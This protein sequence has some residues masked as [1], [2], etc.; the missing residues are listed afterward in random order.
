MQ[1]ND[2]REEEAKRRQEEQLGKLVLAL[3]RKPQVPPT[4]LFE[5]PY[6]MVWL[7]SLKASDPRGQARNCNIFYDLGNY[8]PSFVWY[9]SDHTSQ[10]WFSVGRELHWWQEHWSPLG[11]WLPQTKL[12]RTP[13]HFW[14]VY[15]CGVQRK[16]RSS[17]EKGGILERLWDEIQPKKRKYQEIYQEDMLEE[18]QKISFD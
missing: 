4:E 15:Y 3:G 8:T 18:N 14:V 7:P 2:W 13:F 6:S 16:L 11:R 1:R 12:C 17:T 10:P 5:C 9:F